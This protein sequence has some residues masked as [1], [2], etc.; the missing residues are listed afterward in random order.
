MP[1]SPTPKRDL[2]ERTLNFAVRIVKFC[3]KAGRTTGAE[4]TM[5]TQ[6]LKAG[7]SIGANVEEAQG[8]ESRADFTHK[9]GIA[10]KEAREARYWLRLF[11]LADLVKCEE[12]AS[13]LDEADQLYR[14]LST[15]VARTRE[16]TKKKGT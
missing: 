9:N 7:T 2:V 10:V 14:I 4:R 11:R 16:N 3:R 13:L 6:L 8:A 5:W 12:S 15:I 1:T